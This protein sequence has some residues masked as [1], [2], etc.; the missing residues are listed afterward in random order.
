M[1]IPLKKPHFFK[2]ILPGF[3]DGLNI[4]IGFLKYLR[5]HEHIKHALLKS[6][7]KKWLVKVDGRCFKEGWKKFVEDHDLQ[8]GD[9]LIFRHEGDMEFEVSIF[10]S[11]HCD[12][13]YVEYLEVEKEEEDDDDD[14]EEE[15]EEKEVKVEEVVHT[16]EETSMDFEFKEKSSTSIESSD[17][18][19]SHSE[20]STHKPFGHSRFTCNITPCCFTYGYLRIPKH[21]AF[22]NNHITNKKYDLLLRDEEQRS[23]NVKLH[24]CQ[25]QTYI[26]GGWREFSADYC[27]KEGDRIMFEIVT[28]GE[29]PIWKFHVVTDAKTPM[30]KFQEN[31]T[32]KPKP[33]V[34]S[35]NKDLPDVE[36]AKDMPRSRPHFIYTITRS[37]ISKYLLRVPTL[38]ARENGLDRNCTVTIRDEQQRSWM[39]KLYIN[40]CNISIGGI[41]HEFCAANFLKEGDRVMFEMFSKE[42]GLV[43]KF[44]DLRANASLQCEQKKPNLDVKRVSTQGLEIETSDMPA[45]KAQV[46]APTSANTCPHFIA[47]IKSYTISGSYLCLPM[48]FIKSTGLMDRRKM[49]LTDEKQRSWPVQLSQRVDRFVITKGFQKFMKANGVQVGDT[50]KFELIDNRTLRVEC[51]Y[52]VKDEKHERNHKEH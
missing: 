24:S 30:R 21:V 41:W 43:L 9:L 36:A 11:T 4:P 20:A 6:A 51:K 3:K 33:Y 49:I 8:L 13:E 7:G 5:G 42:E 47:T 38:F 39:F 2:P 46:P 44:H 50:Y 22:A 14:D 52:A 27:L 45:P 17:E 1:K 19:S 18:A 28:D 35:S 25:T 40:A 31:A 34:M 37:C 16:V 15:E 32:K 29:T 26:G 12:R 23:W 10:D 48:A